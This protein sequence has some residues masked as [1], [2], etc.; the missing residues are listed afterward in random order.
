MV[1]LVDI[2]ADSF[3][4]RTKVTQENSTIGNGHVAVKCVEANIVKLNVSIGKV[5]VGHA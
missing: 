3:V 1:K 2:C 5:V 4:C